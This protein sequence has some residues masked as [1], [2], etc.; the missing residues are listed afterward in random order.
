MWNSRTNAILLSFAENIDNS[1][2]LLHFVKQ[3]LENIGLN[4]QMYIRVAG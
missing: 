3:V 4:L 1:L 2:H